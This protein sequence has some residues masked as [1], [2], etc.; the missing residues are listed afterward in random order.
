MKYRVYIDVRKAFCYTVDAESAVE[1]EQKAKEIAYDKNWGVF[2]IDV[3]DI[4]E[5]T[6]D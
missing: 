2:N 6:E 1:A 3:F 4:E 5:V